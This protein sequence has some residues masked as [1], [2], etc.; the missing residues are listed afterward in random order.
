[1]IANV[2]LPASATPETDRAPPPPPTMSRLSSSHPLTHF[3]P[4]CPYCNK[5]TFYSPRDLER[6]IRI[7]TGEKPY[8][9]P[10]C[11][12]QARLKAHM[13][14]HLFRKHKRVMARDSKGIAS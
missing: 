11:N 13:K 10:H 1:M 9:C 12:Y 3:Q 2:T 14:S 7:H 8:R 4:V 5:S 6:H